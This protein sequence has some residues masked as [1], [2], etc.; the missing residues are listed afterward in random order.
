[1][2]DDEALQRSLEALELQV[3]SALS[4]QD[5]SELDVVGSGEISPVLRLVAAGK[6]YAVKRLPLFASEARLQGYVE[7][8]ETDA[9]GW[10]AAGTRSSWAYGTP[11]DTFIMNASSGSNAWF[12]NLTNDYNADEASYL[13]SPCFDFSGFGTDPTMSFSYIHDTEPTNDHAFVEISTDGGETWSKLGLFGTGSNWY[14]DLAGDFW[15]GRSG[16]AGVWVRGTHPLTGAAGSAA[17]RVRV[18][19][20]SN[21]T[22]QREGMGIDDVIVMP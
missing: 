7:T 9:G 5:D 17:V 12:T 15:D 20:V 1:M 16:A 3:Q 14:N 4:R 6:P 11:S 13:V 8:F 21:M 22:V 10:V 18:A 19:F 2:G